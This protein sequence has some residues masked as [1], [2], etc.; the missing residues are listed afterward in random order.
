M[1]C[2]TITDANHRWQTDIT[3]IRVSCADPVLRRVARFY[4]RVRERAL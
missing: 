1:K 4:R 3:G 2:F